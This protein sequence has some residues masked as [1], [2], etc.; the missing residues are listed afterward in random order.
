LILFDLGLPSAIERTEIKMDVAS[1][2]GH[3]K[4]SEKYLRRHSTLHK[5]SHEHPPRD[6]V[7]TFVTLKNFFFTGLAIM[8]SA[9]LDFSD[10]S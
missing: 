10:S 4:P 3:L 1:L 5:I 7:E 9:I 8:T 6:H 2:E